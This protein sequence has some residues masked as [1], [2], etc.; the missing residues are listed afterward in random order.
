[1]T[2]KAI[3]FVL[4]VVAVEQ[5]L[6]TLALFVGKRR[7]GGRLAAQVAQQDE[8]AA[9][10]QQRGPR[11][12]Q[13]GRRL[14]RRLVQDEVAVAVD[15]V[16]EDLVVGPSRGDLLAN[17]AAQIV[18][19]LGVGVSDGLVLA[20]EAAQLVGELDRPRSL[21]RIHLGGRGVCGAGVLPGKRAK[22]KQRRQESRRAAH[23]DFCSSLINGR[24]FFLSASSV[25]GPICL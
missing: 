19:E 20:D 2:T 15:H 13:H 5:A 3:T 9:D 14:E 25:I 1:M 11:P 22:Q 23:Q 17:L 8:E 16:G 4:P 12:E 6:R 7:F 21:H 24:I 10:E 18:R